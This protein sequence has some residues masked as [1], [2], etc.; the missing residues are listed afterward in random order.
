MGCPA[1]I[2]VKAFNDQKFTA[3][4]L[5]QF[6]D[7]KTLSSVSWDG[8]GINN[9]GVFNSNSI[10]TQVTVTAKSDGVIGSALVTVYSLDVSG[11]YAFPV[12]YKANGGSGII[13]FADRVLN[14]LFTSTRPAV[15][16]C[17]MCR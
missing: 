17:S 5:D 14:P 9:A 15:G 10:G 13:H 11:A 7:P 8:S 2:T 12:P 1:T 3:D 16:A 4:G 6:G